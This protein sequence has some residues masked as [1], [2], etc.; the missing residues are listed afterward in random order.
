MAQWDRAKSYVQRDHD[1]ALLYTEAIGD[2]PWIVPQQIPAENWSAYHIWAAEFRGD[3]HGIPYA[4]FMTALR[5]NGGDYFLPSFVPYG[6]FGLDPS[7]V[8]RYPL[9][10]EPLAYGLG[11][12][13]RCPH[14]HGHSD[15]S[16]GLCPAAEHLVPRLLN[17]VLSP[18]SDE[19]VQRYADGL[20]Q[21][22]R[23]YA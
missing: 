20:A 6:A 19:R 1:L 21:T 8:Y 5:A 7:P 23:Q 18:I 22:V 4:D 17:T 3:E 12:P 2:C 10:S 9:F 14:Y 15:Y 16:A 11:C 13:I